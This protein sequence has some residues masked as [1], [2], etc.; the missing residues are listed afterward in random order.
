MAKFFTPPL[1]LVTLATA[2]TFS[3]LFA[4]PTGMKVIHGEASELISSAANCWTIHSGDQTILEWDSF[5]I[6][7]EEILN[8]QQLSNQSAVLNRIVGPESSQLMGQL[9]SNGQVFVINPNGVLIGPQAKIEAA[10]FIASSL[11]ALNEQF[12]TSDTLHFIG[13][14]QSQVVNLGQIHCPAG[15]IVLLGQVVRNEGELLA[16]DGMIAMGASSNVLLSMNNPHSLIQVSLDES[17]EEKTSS[18]PL[19]NEGK[20]KALMVE[21]KNS[22]NPYEMAIQHSGI[23][24]GY[25]E[26]VAIHSEKGAIEITGE[27]LATSQEGK[28]GSVEVLG[29]Q[30]WICNDAFIDASGQKGGGSILI[31]GDFQGAN[32][33][34]QN[35]QHTFVSQNADYNALRPG[36]KNH[37]VIGRASFKYLQSLP[38]RFGILLHGRGQISS[39]NLLPSEQVG[40]GGFDTVRGYTERQ[41]NYDSALLATVELQSPSFRVLGLKRAKFKDNAYFIGFVD[42]GYG[43]NH[44][45]IPGEPNSDYLLGVGPGLRYQ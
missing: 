13:S 33:A 26:Y 27:I 6:S 25:A 30:V 35:A 23:I 31:G 40:L 19:V 32:P 34:I 37:W 16:P 17:S 18:T 8:F 5:S 29:E 3:T 36:A 24:D 22:E 1:F 42:C 15:K 20:I 45:L 10:S 21:L 9:L 38:A 44:N 39:Q 7:T 4:K 28:G 41:L 11:D 43:G 14:K 12:L 2:C